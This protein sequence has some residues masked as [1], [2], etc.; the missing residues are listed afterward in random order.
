MTGCADCGN[1][2]QRTIN[3]RLQKAIADAKIYSKEHN[4]AVAVFVE[5]QGFIFQ[6]YQG[7][8]PPGAVATFKET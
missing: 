6:A 3:E 7:A 2:E 5:G 4:T 8:T 1:Q